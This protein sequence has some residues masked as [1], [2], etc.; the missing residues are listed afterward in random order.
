MNLS[1]HLSTKADR[2]T[3]LLDRLP[4]P[5]RP[6]RDLAGAYK[7]VD[8]ESGLQLTYQSGDDEAFGY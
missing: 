3:Y 6:Y 8:L 7:Q 4:F 2:S 5:V 1:E